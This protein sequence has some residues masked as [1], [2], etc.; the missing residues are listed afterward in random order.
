[1]ELDT[2]AS[3]IEVTDTGVMIRWS[4]G[5]RS[6]FHSLW[7]RHNCPVE[8]PSL[9]DLNPDVFVMFAEQDDDGD[10][11]VEFSDGHESSFPFAWLQ[12]HSHEAH[13]LVPTDSTKSFRAGHEL[14][15][16]TLLDFDDRQRLDC[17]D[18]IDRWGAVIVTEVS[19]SASELFADVFGPSRPTLQTLSPAAQ[20][21]AEHDHEVV[22]PH[23][24]SSWRTDPDGIVIL[25]CLSAADSAGE[26]TLVDG[27]AI[28]TELQDDDPD[29]FDMLSQTAV[30]FTCPNDHYMTSQAP[31]ISV[32]G[33]YRVTSVRFDEQAL[34]P[35]AIEPRQVSEY[36]RAVMEFTQ[37]VNDPG[38]A[39]QVGL[40]PGQA[41]VVDNHRILHGRSV[42]EFGRHFQM[43][44]VDRDWFHRRRRQLRAART[45]LDAAE[46]QL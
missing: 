18:S 36:Y 42:A 8:Q 45:T 34:A 4:D 12:A 32:D 25:Q 11:G 31:V 46:R 28:A 43:T 5:A 27:F 35:L 16:F 38:R 44:S 24:Q 22:A 9:T 26:I 40:E 21:S 41:L 29:A 33:S 1:M 2:A 23:T 15:Q 6:R 17:L 14:E 7:L 10:L 30:T 13:E 3:T 19:E 37:K 20:G 39:I